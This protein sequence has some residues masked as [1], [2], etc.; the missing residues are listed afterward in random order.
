MICGRLQ[1]TFALC[2]LI[3]KKR[4]S[5]PAESL[6]PLLLCETF[7]LLM[8]APLDTHWRLRLCP[9]FVPPGSETGEVKC[10]LIDNCR[11]TLVNQRKLKKRKDNV[12]K[13]FCL[14]LSWMRFFL[15][16]SAA[17]AVVVVVWSHSAEKVSARCRVVSRAP[18]GTA[19]GEQLA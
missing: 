12:Q 4:Q 15:Y 1:R 6:P 13:G 7:K 18:Y 5:Q 8:A 3:L 11:I 17:A 16:V 2:Y 14:S 10:I 9:R 19:R